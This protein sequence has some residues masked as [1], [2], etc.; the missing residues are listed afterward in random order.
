M[1]QKL[2]FDLILP[3]FVE[4][5]DYFYVINGGYG[6]KV[7]MTLH[8]V[9]FYYK[10]FNNTHKAVLTNYLSA[11]D[12]YVNN[13]FTVTPEGDKIISFTFTFDKFQ[14][15]KIN[16]IQNKKSFYLSEMTKKRIL[17]FSGYSQPTVNALLNLTI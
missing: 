10:V 8:R 16:L 9:T 2:L 5:S 7:S 12:N 13:I 6:V 15:H 4:P 3:L 14:K 17:A 1:D 11:K